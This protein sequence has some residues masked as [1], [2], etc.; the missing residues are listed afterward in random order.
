MRIVVYT[1]NFGHY[2]NYKNLLQRDKRVKYLYYSD[3]DLVLD[4]YKCVKLNPKDYHKD[5]HKASRYP[6]ICSHKVLPG[7]DYSIYMDASFAFDIKN[8]VNFINNLNG[9]LIAQF[10]HGSIG[11]RNYSI[12]EEA[13]VCMHKKLDNRD[14]IRQQMN[15]Y[16]EE[17]FPDNLGLYSGGFIVRKN[18]PLVNRFNE[19]WW[20]EVFNGSR[21]DQLSEMYALWK[22]GLN[23][24]TLDGSIYDVDYLIKEKHR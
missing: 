22:S 2:D 23:M 16:K 9:A 18:D 14:V 24:T 3:E 7:H 12:G 13:I 10:F 21:R 17:A 15:R 6:K 4:G 20:N 11:S 19:L 5:I 1:C 8:V